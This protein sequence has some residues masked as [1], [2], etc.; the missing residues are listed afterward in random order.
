MTDAGK[1]TDDMNE[2]SRVAEGTKLNGLIPV[3]TSTRSDEATRTI[4]QALLTGQLVPGQ[5]VKEVDLAAVL[6][7]SRQTAREAMGELI[8]EGTLVREPYKGV[9]VAEITPQDIL[10]VSEIRLSLETLAAL[11]IAGQPDRAGLQRLKEALEVHL[12]ALDSGDVVAADLTHLDFHRTMYE[13]AGNPLLIKIWPLVAARIQMAITLD[14]SVRQDPERD[15]ELHQ[16]LYDTIAAGDP[17][18]ISAEVKYHVQD[19][20]RE[21]APTM[22]KRKAAGR[23]P[24]PPM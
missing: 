13:A 8:H 3:T 20:A 5:R 24:G 17:E 10:D 2:P 15:R 6:N 21:I 1:G 22:D 4:R 11:R 9:R 16:R 7:V 14:Q 12:T 19:A 18:A 23:P